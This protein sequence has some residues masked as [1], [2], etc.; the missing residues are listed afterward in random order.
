M[1]SEQVIA[2]ITSEPKYYI[3]VHEQSTA[4]RI[5]KRYKEGRITLNKLNE[6]IEAYGYVWREGEW[7]KIKVENPR[8]KFK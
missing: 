7:I 5:V 1:N 8:I 2:E 3:G 4:S 6:F